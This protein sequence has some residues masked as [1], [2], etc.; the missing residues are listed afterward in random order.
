MA[1]ILGRLKVTIYSVSTRISTTPVFSEASAY[2]GKIL[3]I[4]RHGFK[5]LRLRNCFQTRNSVRRKKI[6]SKFVS[7]TLEEG[8]NVHPTLCCGLT[9]ISFGCLV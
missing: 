6:Q 8:D 5:G 3:G 2:N 7:I 4:Q 9:R 1:F